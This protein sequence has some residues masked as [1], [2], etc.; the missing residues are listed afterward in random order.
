MSIDKR[1]S[2]KKENLPSGY[3][4]KKKKYLQTRKHISKVQY[5]NHIPLCGLIR[6]QNRYQN[7]MLS[8]LGQRTSTEAPIL[9]AFQFETQ[10]Q[11]KA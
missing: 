3:D 7:K 9:K 1:T 5:E 8:Y 2:N 6:I 10:F 11:T 4:L